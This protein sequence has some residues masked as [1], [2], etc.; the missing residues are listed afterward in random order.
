MYSPDCS[1]SLEV[2]GDPALAMRANT[3]EIPHGGTGSLMMFVRQC[4]D[5]C[6]LATVFFDCL[7][8]KIFGESKGF[9]N[10]MRY[11]SAAPESFAH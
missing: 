10:S 9:R 1:S 3:A 2:S 4:Q 6:L 11:Y 7:T 8:N 5:P